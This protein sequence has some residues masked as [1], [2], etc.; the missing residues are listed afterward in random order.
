MIKKLN[1]LGDQRILDQKKE[2]NFSGPFWWHLNLV[3]PDLKSKKIS[4]L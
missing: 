4:A 2:L 1:L 3:Q